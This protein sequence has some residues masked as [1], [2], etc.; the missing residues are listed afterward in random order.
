MVPVDSNPQPGFGEARLVA[1]EGGF[2]V[3]EAVKAGGARGGR[4]PR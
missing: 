3:V 1:Q 2:K 4:P